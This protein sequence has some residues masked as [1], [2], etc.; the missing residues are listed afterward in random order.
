MARKA[1]K[2]VEKLIL[3]IISKP[4][5]RGFTT[6]EIAEK[7][8]LRRQTISKY[9]YGLEKSKELEIEVVGRTTLIFPKGGG[10]S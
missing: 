9:I 5:R 1:S 7:I 10:G 4:S 3:S 6:D 2:E 8:G